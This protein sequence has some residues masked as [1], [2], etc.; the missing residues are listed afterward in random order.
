MCTGSASGCARRA[1]RSTPTVRAD[2]SI[3]DQWL[4]PFVVG[5]FFG[6]QDGDACILF[7]FRGDRAIEISRAFQD[8][9]HLDT[10]FDRGRRPD[11]L[12]VGMMEY[13]GDLHIPQ[14]TLVSPPA[15]TGTVAEALAD[16]NRRTYACSETQKF[17]HVTYFFN[18]NR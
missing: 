4:K 3:D 14:Q 7:N 13:D 1:R 2:A 10:G 6:M 18:G 5:D 9:R 12:F 11:V 16:A 8:G 15:I 17:G